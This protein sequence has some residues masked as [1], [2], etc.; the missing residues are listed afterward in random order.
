MLLYI[1]KKK[2]VNALEDIDEIDTDSETKAAVEKWKK[3]GSVCV[4]E[5]IASMTNFLYRNAKTNGSSC[6]ELPTRNLSI[7]NN[8]AKLKIYVELGVWE[9]SYIQQK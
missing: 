3:C 5:R 1:W 4:Y 2:Q 8:K 9:S 6:V 7:P